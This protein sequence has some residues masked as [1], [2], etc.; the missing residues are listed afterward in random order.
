MAFAR[1]RDALLITGLAVGT[2]TAIRAS[3]DP[4][5]MMTP[6]FEVRHGRAIIAVH[7]G[8]GIGAAAKLLGVAQSTLS[9]TLLSLERMIGAP[10][11]TRRAGQIARLTAPA[12]AMLPYARTLVAASETALVVGATGA[13]PTIIR[14]GT[15]ES[16]SSFVLPRPLTKFRRDWPRIDVRV[17]T[18]LCEDLRRRLQQAQLDAVIMMD[19]NTRDAHEAITEI[20]MLFVVRSSHYLADGREILSDLSKETF[21]LSEA[22]GPMAD[23]V[24][25]WSGFCNHE[26]RIQSAGSVEGVKRGVLNDDAIGVLPDYTV[27]DDLSSGSLITLRSTPALPKATLRLATMSPPSDGTPLANLLTHLREAMRMREPSE[28]LTT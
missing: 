4:M 12:E 19:G 3:V 13:L 8:G 1:H 17:T 10:V 11:I 23:L 26:L 22:E 6:Y 18:G 7:E 28:N 15:V 9:E 14:L 24:K 2:K 5:G 21:L 16:I 25:T 27:V 20:T